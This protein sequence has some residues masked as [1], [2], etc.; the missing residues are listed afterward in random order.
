MLLYGCVRKMFI[1]LC[2]FNV[3]Y[4][5]VLLLTLHLLQHSA[6]LSFRHCL[7]PT[8]LRGDGILASLMGG[9]LQRWVGSH[10]WHDVRHALD[11]Q[12][13]SHGGMDS[14]EGGLCDN[15]D[16]TGLVRGAYE[17]RGAAPFHN[18]WVSLDV[19]IADDSALALN[20]EGMLLPSAVLLATP[21]PSP[22]TAANSGA[23]LP[24]TID[25]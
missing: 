1:C 10:T 3:L 4:A 20:T 6:A 17:H 8:S 21:P 7:R 2:L 23:S 9:D 19:S 24:S 14:G 22:A 11:D 15:A 12:G 25:S 13:V 18:A 16:G 5:K